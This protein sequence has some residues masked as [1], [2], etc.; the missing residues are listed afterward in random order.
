MLES[1]I[2]SVSLSPTLPTPMYDSSMPSMAFE[3]AGAQPSAALRAASSAC[4]AA[5]ADIA[6]VAW[7][8]PDRDA[9]DS[10]RDG[11]NDGRRALEWRGEPSA[12]EF[13]RAAATAA[14]R[15]PPDLDRGTATPVAS[16]TPS[17][18]PAAAAADTGSAAAALLTEAE[19]M[20]MLSSV[21]C[22]LIDRLTSIDGRHPSSLEGVVDSPTGVCETPGPAAKADPAGPAAA[23]AA[24]A[25]AGRLPDE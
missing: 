21:C 11:E 3:P 10:R 6:A 20:D 25:A 19:S 7:G 17:P 18:A 16:T 24:S 2:S 5:S 15:A 8:D 1:F 22:L 12:P 14:T 9:P 4:A 13:I 23:A